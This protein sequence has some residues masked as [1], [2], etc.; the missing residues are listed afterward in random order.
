MDRLTAFEFIA[1]T[2]APQV[3]RLRYKDIIL[4]TFAV[5]GWFGWCPATVDPAFDFEHRSDLVIE[6]QGLGHPYWN[7][8][9]PSWMTL[10]DGQAE[11]RRIEAI[12]AAVGRELNRA[13]LHF[14]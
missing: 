14:Q 1:A 9:Q 6:G 5:V 3:V 4:V 8:E 7:D 12:R 2:D 13:A 10:F 11:R